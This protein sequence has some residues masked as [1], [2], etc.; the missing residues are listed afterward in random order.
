[1]DSNSLAGCKVAL[2]ETRQLDALA[3]MLESQGA[4]PLRY[5]LVA[6]LDSDD[7]A[8]VN[9]WLQ[10]LVDG[11][12][13]DVLFYTGEGFRRLLGFADRTIGREKV[14]SSLGGV[15]K[16]CRGPKPAQALREHGMRADLKVEPATTAGIVETLKGVDLQSH[17][18][19]IQLFDQEIPAPLAEYLNATNITYHCVSPYRYAPASDTDKVLELI[20]RLEEGQVDVIAFT[21]ASQV[22]RLWEVATRA[23]RLAALEK[24]MSQVKV[25]AVGPVVAERLSD[26]GVRV[27][28]I[29]GDRYFM[30]PLVDALEASFREN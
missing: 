26:R 18:L 16:I 2:P 4:I 17:V 21:S 3:R 7:E 9:Q 6:I 24:G 10:M 19:G 1:M 5:P 12:F 14:L 30:R 22:D 25:A 15:R 28:V 11:R 23:D 20:D 27:D 13:T 29:P 8:H